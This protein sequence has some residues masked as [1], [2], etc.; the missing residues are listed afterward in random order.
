[1]GAEIGNNLEDKSCLKDMVNKLYDIMSMDNSASIF[2]L[3]AVPTGHNFKNKLCP[4][5]FLCVSG[6]HRAQEFIEP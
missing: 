6:T 4:V 2:V 1:M 3:A 5:D